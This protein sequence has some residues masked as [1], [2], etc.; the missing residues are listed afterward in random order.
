MENEKLVNV[1]QRLLTDS[2]VKQEYEALSLEYQ[3]IE[4]LVQIRLTEQLTL[5]EL[6]KRIGIPKSNISR[7]EHR[8]H[9]PTIETL[10]RY[11]AG[12]N[13]KIVLT[14]SDRKE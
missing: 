1:R 7:F 8:K 13:K 4:Q 5:D 6:S 14:I 2:L 12:L 11:A 9:S 3:L 10:I